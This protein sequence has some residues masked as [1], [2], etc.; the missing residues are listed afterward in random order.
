VATPHITH[1]YIWIRHNLEIFMSGVSYCMLSFPGF[2]VFF[3]LFSG[4]VLEKG[5]YNTIS[6]LTSVVFFF[7]ILAFSC[8]C[9]FV[10]S[11]YTV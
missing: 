6:H 4:V 8:D 11:Q 5:R 10:M 3:A 7:L 9:R 2:F 1:F